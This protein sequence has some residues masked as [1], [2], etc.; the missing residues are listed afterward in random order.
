MSESKIEIKT[1]DG[2]APAYVFRPQ[3]E[4]HWPAVLFYMDAI[5]IRPALFAMAERLASHGYYV[6][7]PD[8]F[9]RSGSYA[10]FDAATAFQDEAEQSRLKSLTQATSNDKA[11]RD[12]DAFLKFLSTQSAVRGDKVGCV[13][14]CMG[15]RFAL[16]AAGT[17]PERVAAAACFHGA[18]LATDAPDSPHLLAPNMRGELYIG[19]AGIDQHFTEQEKLRLQ[20][21]LDAAHVRYSL[22]VYPN[23]RHGFAVNDTLVYDRDAAE[24][25]WEKTLELFGR[26]LA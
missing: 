9:Y 23:A 6:L 15:G 7:L 26:T 3:G 14:Y 10:R 20:D 1:H 21:A 2:V 17:S 18:R 25:H 24:R 4:G 19:V 13:G 16:V 11:A 5:A 8:L 12:T 22:E